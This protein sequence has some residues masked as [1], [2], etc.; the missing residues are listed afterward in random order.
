[1]IKKLIELIRYRQLIIT[2][3]SRELKARYRGTFFGFLWSLINPLLLL[4]VY[5]IVFGMI[6]PNDSGRV[7]MKDITGMNYSIFLFT[8]LLPWI[9]FNSSILE[10]SNVLFTHGNLIKKISFPVEVLPIMTV[11]TNMIHFI[12]GLP[13][14]ALFIIIFGNGIHLTLWLLFLPI[15]LLVQFIFIMGFSFFVSALT[16]HFRDLKDILANFLT[17]WFFGTPIIYAFGAPS[18]Q[19]HKALIWVLNLNPMTHIIEA[20]QYIFV[21]GSLPHYK[22][23]TVTL[24]VGIIMF[25]LGYLLFDKLRDT[26]V[27]EV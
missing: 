12:L 10:A 2:L 13:I 1:M 5:S 24:I 22:R 17:L 20:Y 14:L 3:V 8:G 6:L 11:L 21:F 25:Y 16:V 18:I 27:E 15:A 23:L 19:K 26:F 9:W 4:I 7:E